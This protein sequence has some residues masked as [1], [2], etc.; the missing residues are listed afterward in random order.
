MKQYKV[1]KPYRAAYENPIRV[2]A[3]EKVE[4]GKIE[5]EFPGWIWCTTESGNSGWGPKEY[6]E[7]DG[8]GGRFVRDYDATE[9]TVDEGARV[10]GF[11]EVAGWVWCRTEEGYEGWVPGTCLEVV[12]RGR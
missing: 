12:N 11:Q 3:R 5:D 2:K 1:I 8:D 6:L 7:I 9:L 4:L 10:T